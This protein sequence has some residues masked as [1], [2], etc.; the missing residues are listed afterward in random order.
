MQKAA[1]LVES[2]MIVVLLGV[3]LWQRYQRTLKRWW[4]AGERSRN[5]PGRCSHGH[6]RTVKTAG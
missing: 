1:L 2:I 6:Q 5:G 3:V 4:K